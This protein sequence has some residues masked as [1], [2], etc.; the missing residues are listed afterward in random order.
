MKKIILTILATLAVLGSKTPSHAAGTDRG[1]M[2]VEFL[3]VINYAAG[4]TEKLHE[5]TEI[6]FDRKSKELFIVDAAKHKVLVYDQNGLFIQDIQADGINGGEGAPR[7]V[8]VDGKGRIFTS[9]QNSPKINVMDY[10]GEYLDSLLLPGSIDQPGNT[11]VPTFMTVGADGKIYALKNVGGMVRLDPDGNSQEEISIAG[12]GAPNMI[13]GM[14]VDNT[15]RFLFTDMRPYSVVIYDPGKKTFKRFGKGGVLYEQL[16]RPVGI[17]TDDAGH[18]FVVNTVTNKVSCF[19]RDGNFIEEF[20]KLGE[21]F[22]QFYMPSRVVSDGKDRLYVLENTLKRVQVFKV[23]FLK[24][25][26][27]MQGSAVSSKEHG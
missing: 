24:E 7:A 23:E 25:R 8:A 20:G 1:I 14:T 2:K 5:P 17:T 26:E 21:R 10:K 16:D 22:G 11:V 3:Y 4:R 6:F 12:D 27:V 13:Y 9:Y 15:G 19:D 18:I